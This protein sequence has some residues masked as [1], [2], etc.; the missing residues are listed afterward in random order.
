[1][2]TM[3]KLIR[4]IGIATT[5]ALG[6]TAGVVSVSPPASAQ[7][8]VRPPA[9]A[10]QNATPQ[11]AGP[12][13]DANEAGGRGAVPADDLW[14]GIRRGAQ[15]NV[16]IPD[17]KAGVLVQSGGESWRNFRNGPL[18]SYGAWSMAAV[19]GLLGLFFLVRG[20]INIEA[21]WSGRTIQRFSDLDRTAHW[22]MAVSFIVLGFSGLNV[23]YGKY[24]LL[25]VLGPEVFSGLSAFM[26]WIH[27]H[28][29]FAFMAGLALSFVMWVK[30]N[31]PNRYDLQW[32]AQG[33]GMFSKHGHPPA[34]KF[35]AGQK[36]LF[37]MIMLGGV[38]IS[39]SGL[40]LMFPFQASLFT[41]TFGL[42]SVFGLSLPANPTGLQEMQFASVWHAILGVFLICVIFAH[43]YIGTLG[44]QGAFEAMGNGH[45]DENW[46]KEHHSVWA[47]EE[48]AK[49]VVERGLGNRRPQPAE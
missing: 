48:L 2:R 1:M 36:I 41:K 43:V 42:I 14:G 19:L 44:M 40:A 38:A 3:S 13:A 12:K 18:V 46:A 47:E 23:L 10:V 8:T 27:N 45:V 4:R 11:N 29:A 17:K 24:V 31:F 25:P 22:L 35:N 16:T 9:G 5:L 49:T 15:G 30:H 21:G 28:V 26:K 20:R 33:G 32:L 39:L 34:K 7:S 37:W 6:L